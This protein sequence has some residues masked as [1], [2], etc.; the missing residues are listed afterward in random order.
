M[1]GPT[2]TTAST[3]ARPRTVTLPSGGVR[4]SVGMDIANDIKDFLMSR[5]ARISPGQVGLPTGGR[6]RVP[7]LRRE[8]VAKM[9]GVSIEYYI[10][11][12]RGNVAGVSDE[13]LHAI[14]RALRFGEA[15]ETH[16]FDLVRAAT[17]KAERPRP[18]RGQARTIPAGVQALLDSM[19]T[20]PAIVVNGQLDV[21][22]ANALGRALFAPVFAHAEQ[23]PNAARFMFVDAAAGQFLPEWAKEADDVV[24]LLR[25]EAARSPDS[26]AVTRLVD[27]LATRS[28]EFRTRWAAHNVKAHRHGVKRFRLAE[29]GELVLT[30]NV[31]DITGRGEL[32]LIGYSAQQ[33]SRS[34]AALRMLASWT[35]TGSY[36]ARNDIATT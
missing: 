29:V 2:A 4:V 32:S 34:E 3:C 30:Y 28:Q 5:R 24:A 19:V 36:A 9:A 31:L 35:A 11:I 10:Q 18:A 1:G 20:A 17:T 7:G 6:R 8:E 16:L 22:A 14:A 25:A 26:P 27:E 33:D 13:V 15:E 23:T 12:E 21:V